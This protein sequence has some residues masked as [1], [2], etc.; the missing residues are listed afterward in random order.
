[1]R[2]VASLDSSPMSI[3]PTRPPKQGKHLL[4]S[5][6]IKVCYPAVIL[7]R[8]RTDSFTTAAWATA[9]QGAMYKLSIL[10]LSDEAKQNLTDCTGILG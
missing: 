4:S 1:M 8:F 9:F 6:L 10:G 7:E 5:P 2:L 3:W